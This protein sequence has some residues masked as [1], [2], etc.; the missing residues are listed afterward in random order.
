MRLSLTATVFMNSS[1]AKTS[2]SVTVTDIRRKL[3]PDNTCGR[4]H[5]SF[6]ML[7]S[8]PQS[9]VGGNGSSMFLAPVRVL[10]NFAHRGDCLSIRRRPDRMVV[11][12]NHVCGATYI[13]ELGYAGKPPVMVLREKVLRIDFQP[14]RSRL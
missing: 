14:R 7:T 8:E 2:S 5:K 10:V 1:F 4:K 9:T 13:D 12:G 11:V 6:L 3:K